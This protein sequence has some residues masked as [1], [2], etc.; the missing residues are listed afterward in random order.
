ME[1]QEP[2]NMTIKT[3]KSEHDDRS[4]SGMSAS[5]DGGRIPR[6]N[7]KKKLSETSIKGNKITQDQD[8]I[9]KEAKVVSSI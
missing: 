6:K 1:E 4:Y 3:N 5:Q 7:K 2:K 9:S 8:S